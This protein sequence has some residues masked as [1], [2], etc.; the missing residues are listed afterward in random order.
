M[1]VFDST[2][3]MLVLWPNSPAP[4]DPLTGDLVERHVDRVNFL[5]E[6]LTKARTSIIIPTP[7]LSEVL[8]RAGKYASEY[9]NRIDKSGFYRIEP[10]DTR[11]AIEVALMVR[12]AL[13]KGDKTGG[14]EGVWAKIKYDRQ[15]IAISKV[16]GASTIFS[17][18][19]NLRHFGQAS[20][21]KV[22]GLGECPLPP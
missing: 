13:D 1:V 12:A 8:V 15:I 14:G 20:G 18:D 6:T 22:I 11:A 21:L 10:F 4:K 16:I 17:D 2:M 3:M 5:L 9:V 7:V 19:K